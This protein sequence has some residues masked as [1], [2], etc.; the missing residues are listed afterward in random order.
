MPAYQGRALDTRAPRRR[1]APWARVARVLVAIVALVALAHVPWSAVA[2]RVVR[3]DA[4]R[5]E[6]LHYLDEAAVLHEAGLEVGQSWLDADVA[7]ARQALLGDSRI[8]T[9]RVHREPPNRLAVEIEERVPVALVRHG[10]P[11]EVDGDGVLLAPLKEGVVA[12]VPLIDGAAAEHFAAGTCLATP[13]VRRALAWVSATAPPEL[14]LAGRIS[15][16][17]V[18]DSTRTGLVLDNGTRVVAAAWPPGARTLSALRVVL[19]DLAHRGTTADEV[20]L[21]FS[22]IVIVRPATGAADAVPALAK[23]PSDQRRG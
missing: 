2:R 17:D 10:G 23:A 5:V 15:E 7:R 12:D 16:I 18:S 21:R 9:A 6:G 22:K 3:V 4:I 1:S 8:R 19:A 14:E 11:W 13:P 20:D